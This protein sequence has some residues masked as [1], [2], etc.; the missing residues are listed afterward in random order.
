MDMV[1]SGRDRQYM[2][3]W[4]RATNLDPLQDAHG[5][6]GARLIDEVFGQG[7]VLEIGGGTGNGIRLL[8]RLAE[9]DCLWRF[10]SYVF[11][12]I[13][14]PFI[15]ATRQETRRDYPSVKTEWRHLDINEPIGTQRVEPESFDLIYGVNAAHVARDI[16]AFLKECHNTLREGGKVVFSERVRVKS[17][18]MAPREL[19]LNLCVYH[20]TAAIRNPEYRPLHAYLATE[21]WLRPLEMAGFHRARVCP[22]LKALADSFPNQYAAVVVGE[23]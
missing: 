21:H 4:H 18:E 2:N 20:R 6:M 17:C 5:K 9:R 14:L 16:L 11:T 22:N 13:S 7:R 3:L 8:R 23:N 10:E 12:D 1:L 19:T 15:L